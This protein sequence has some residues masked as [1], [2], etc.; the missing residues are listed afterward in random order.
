MKNFLQVFFTVSLC[1]F[2]IPICPMMALESDDMLCSVA[3]KEQHYEN[4]EYGVLVDKLNFAMVRQKQELG[5]NNDISGLLELRKEYHNY[6]YELKQ[7]SKIELDCLNFNETQ[8]NAI[9]SFDGSDEKASRA[10]AYISATLKLTQFKYTSSDKRTHTS[11]TFSGKWAGTPLYKMQD[12]IAIGM[13]G[14]KSR[15]VK[16]SSSNAITHADGKV[17]RNT[18]SAYP[19]FAGQSY[20]FGIASSYNK[21]F[22]SF[23]MTYTAMADGKNTLID[24]GAIYVHYKQ[25]VASTGITIG[26]SGTGAS[27]GICFTIKGSHD[28]EWKN[29][30]SRSSYV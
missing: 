15:F 17:V 8:I 26:A 5:Y 11:A 3:D 27:I 29:I 22:K 7:K 24:Y 25:T 6:I 4:S 10:S 1:T 28:I 12:S 19:S 2:L 14:S 23:T 18:L 20:K 21:V 30:Y 9:K 16:K 13:I